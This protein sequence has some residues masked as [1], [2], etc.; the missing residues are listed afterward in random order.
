[1]SC[2]KL[3][4]TSVQAKDS[5]CHGLP[6]EKYSQLR[7]GP[8]ILAG[9]WLPSVVSSGI[10]VLLWLPVSYPTD[11]SFILVC[12]GEGAEG[13]WCVKSR[14]CKESSGLLTPSV[15]LHAVAEIGLSDSSGPMFLFC[16]VCSY[17][18]LSIS[19]G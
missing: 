10:S 18:V 6:R 8:Q 17:S 15:C 2:A 9:P 19:Q 14:Y 11:F 12:L 1:M 5:D 13:V 7:Q 3:P 16:K 4:L